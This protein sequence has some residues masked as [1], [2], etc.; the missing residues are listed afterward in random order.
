MYRK[1]EY[2]KSKTPWY[3]WESKN[4]DK[5]IEGFSDEQI[6]SD[7]NH[8]EESY[9]EPN[10]T[11]EEIEEEIRV[12]EEVDKLLNDTENNLM[13]LNYTWTLIHKWFDRNDLRQKMVAYAY[14]LWGLDFVKLI[15]CENGNRD[16][17]AIGDIGKAFW[18]CQMNTNYHKLPAEYKDNRV[19]QVEYCYKKWKWWT[20]YYWPNRKI[21][22]V[23]CSTYVSDRFILES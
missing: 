4:R 21:K 16:I 5:W 7:K 8:S 23:K 1:L 19:V 11:F 20:K 3:S 2:W 22:G 18:L 15:E 17:K 12:I 14:K 9:L 10:P 13:K 6:S